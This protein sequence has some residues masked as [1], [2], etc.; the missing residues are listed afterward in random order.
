MKRFLLAALA[1]CITGCA[2][3]GPKINKVTPSYDKKEWTVDEIGNDQNMHP[4]GTGKFIL[5]YKNI[6]VTVRCF[7]G[8]MFVEIVS[9]GPGTFL[10]QDIPEDVCPLN[11]QES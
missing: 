8:K 11:H 10:W 7:D 2:S 4:I 9:R 6:T 5:E 1:A 3:A